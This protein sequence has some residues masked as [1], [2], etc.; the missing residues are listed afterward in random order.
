MFVVARTNGPLISV[1][2]RLFVLVLR[3]Q[4]DRQAIGDVPSAPKVRLEKAAPT[5]LCVLY[6]A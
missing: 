2:F 3:P 6:N 5:P 4:Q 1:G